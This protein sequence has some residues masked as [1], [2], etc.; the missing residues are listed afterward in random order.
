[1]EKTNKQNPTSNSDNKSPQK[2]K[3]CLFGKY[4]NTLEQNIRKIKLV[5]SLLK[6]KSIWEDYL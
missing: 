1:M 2:K 4:L 5:N 6:Q 3:V